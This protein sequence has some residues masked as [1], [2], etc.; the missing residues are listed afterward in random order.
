MKSSKEPSSSF[1]IDDII[2]RV[3]VE[4]LAGFTIV[5][6]HAADGRRARKA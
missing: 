4:V 5:K 2:R 1:G 3:D 6:D